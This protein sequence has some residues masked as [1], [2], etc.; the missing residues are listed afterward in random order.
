MFVKQRC[1][2]VRRS[3]RSQRYAVG[4]VSTELTRVIHFSLALEQTLEIG[5]VGDFFFRKLGLVVTT[6]LGLYYRTRKRHQQHQQR[7]KRYELSHPVFPPALNLVSR[8]RE[9]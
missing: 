6:V 1:P 8:E 4:R 7:E 9:V 2:R 5:R 3:L